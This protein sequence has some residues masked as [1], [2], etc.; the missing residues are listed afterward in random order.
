M[1]ELRLIE[2]GDLAPGDVWVGDG[3]RLEVAAVAQE[4]G[5]F[6]PWGSGRSAPMVAMQAVKITG[7]LTRPGMH[8]PFLGQWTLQEDQP[9]E[10]E[11]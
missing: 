8:G 2:A 11:R 9:L 3:T 1:A 4:P 10:V 5:L 7:K 6:Q